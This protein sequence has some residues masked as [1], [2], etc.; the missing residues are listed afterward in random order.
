MWNFSCWCQTGGASLNRDVKEEAECALLRLE[1]A[2]AS[3]PRGS[4]VSVSPDLITSAKHSRFHQILIHARGEQ[5]L[6]AHLAAPCR[7]RLSNVPS[8]SHKQV[9]GETVFNKNQGLYLELLSELLR[10]RIVLQTLQQQLRSNSS[11]AV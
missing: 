11:A 9:S 8:G 1:R 2:E 10:C 6:P 3:F 4:S 7:S 5:E